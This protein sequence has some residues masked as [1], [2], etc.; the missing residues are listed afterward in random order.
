MPINQNPVVSIVS[1]HFF[2]REAVRAVTKMDGV[3][4][5]TDYFGKNDPNTPI[6]TSV[7]RKDGCHVFTNYFDPG[8]IKKEH[9][10]GYSTSTQDDARSKITYYHI[11]DTNKTTP[12]GIAEI[13]HY[14]KSYI[15]TYFD[16]SDTQKQHPLGTS[17]TKRD[18]A[19]FTTEY[20]FSPE[21][22]NA[23]KNK[24]APQI[25][26]HENPHTLHAKPKAPP[27]PQIAQPKNEKNKCCSIM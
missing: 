23:Q 8:D 14:D 22:I 25:K 3:I 10:I 13:S 24:P 12:I 6:G 1:M 20:E 26:L 15:A 2:N 27:E 4:F 18:F 7:G 9:P 17:T 16:P 5:K 21:A 19:W 11:N